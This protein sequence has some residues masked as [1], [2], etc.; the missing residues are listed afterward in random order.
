MKYDEQ[1]VKSYRIKSPRFQFRLL[2]LF[3][4]TAI[5]F[6]AFTVVRAG[7]QGLWIAISMSAFCFCVCAL[8]GFLN[9]NRINRNEKAIANKSVH[10]CKTCS[11][12][13][14][15]SSMICPRCECHS[16]GKLL[17]Q[18]QGTG[19]AAGKKPRS[20]AQSSESIRIGES[21]ISA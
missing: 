14:A 8:R 9:I 18:P 4:L 16:C 13:L 1:I 15:I 17:G 5:S 6:D 21:A 12:E 20:T 11:R 3:V 2:I 7:A 10:E 19:P